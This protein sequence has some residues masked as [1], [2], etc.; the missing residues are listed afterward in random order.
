MKWYNT[1]LD[2]IIKLLVGVIM[3]GIQ[4]TL[5]YIAIYYSW[6]GHQVATDFIV[7]VVVSVLSLLNVVTFWRFVLKW[8]SREGF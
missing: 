5:I 3:S 8:R 7:A 1:S 6:V 4:A 2:E